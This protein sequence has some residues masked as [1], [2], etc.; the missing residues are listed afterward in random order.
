MKKNVLFIFIISSVCCFSQKKPSVNNCIIEEGKIIFTDEKI[1]D[2][3]YATIWVKNSINDEEILRNVFLSYSSE[4]DDKSQELVQI[5]SDGHLDYLKDIKA[6]QIYE[7][8]YLCL[9]RY[10]V[11]VLNEYKDLMDRNKAKGLDTNTYRVLV[12]ISPSY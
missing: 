10:N 2:T 6:A 8:I 5:V 9:I 3:I 7:D 1:E 11:F 4:I 12:E